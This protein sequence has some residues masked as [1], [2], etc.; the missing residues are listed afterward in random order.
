MPSLPV[1]QVECLSSPIG[2]SPAHSSSC[3]G[4][5]I[6]NDDVR[7][8]SDDGLA[9]TRYSPIQSRREWCRGTFQSTVICSPR[10]NRSAPSARRDTACTLYRSV[11]YADRSFASRLHHHTR[12]SSAPSSSRGRKETH[13]MTS[14]SRDCCRRN[15]VSC[16]TSDNFGRAVDVSATKQKGGQGTYTWPRTPLPPLR[17]PR[18]PSRTYRA[19]P[20]RHA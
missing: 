16:T 17:Y 13:V 1:R 12:F 20:A 8:T 18:T 9:P 4:I 10:W 15:L 19:P 3:A 14:F 11:A 2:Q 6:P 7:V 5:H